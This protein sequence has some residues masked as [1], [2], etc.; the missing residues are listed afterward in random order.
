MDWSAGNPE[1]PQHRLALALAG[2]ALVLGSAGMAHAEPPA[3]LRL[4]AAA[5]PSAEQVAAELGPLLPHTELVLATEEGE[6]AESPENEASASVE[7]AGEVMRIKVA[8]QRRQFPDAARACKERAKTAAVFIGLVLDPP[9]LPERRP[10]PAPP[11]PEPPPPPPPRA[12]T[13]S[14]EY[15]LKLGPLLQA[16]P[17][18]D[19][20]L[21]PVAGGFGGRLG[22]GQGFGVS[23]G[24]ALLLPTRLSLPHADA[25]VVWL[26]F[27]VSARK[28]F[29]LDAVTLDFELGPELALLFVSGDRVKNPR[30]STRLEVGA[31]L[32]T[33]LIW[34]MSQHL[35]AYFT[36]LGVVRP[37]P[38]DFSVNPGVASGSTPPLWLGASLGFSFRTGRH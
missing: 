4:H 16:A 24:A 6:S 2:A 26:P 27:D 14:T 20:K 23:L 34:N 5:C 21:V 12:P 7:D 8:G 17:V 11:P 10:K 35:G 15:S 28:A 19:A 18:S 1:H 33:S 3:K 31:R 29:E 30:T 22:I 9:L 37:K 32:S 25:R 36:L 38:Y 13:P